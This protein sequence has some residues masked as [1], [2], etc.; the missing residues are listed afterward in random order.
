[1]PGTEPRAGCI[2]I[3]RPASRL[4]AFQCLHRKQETQP[5]FLFWASHG[6]PVNAG[7]LVLVVSY[8]RAHPSL[9]K[10][11]DPMGLFLPCLLCCI[12]EGEKKEMTVQPLPKAFPVP[13][14]VS[15]NIG[16]GLLSSVPTLDQLQ[17][18]LQPAHNPSTPH[19]SFTCRESGFPPLAPLTSSPK[20]SGLQTGS[21]LVS[22]RCFTWPA[23]S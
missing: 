21:R 20:K 1:M 5:T 3:P 11:L 14:L 8:L 17:L 13:W 22:G 18:F 15:L 4:L 16:R 12:W 7:S 23:T 19:F 9:W 2:G 10:P 6:L